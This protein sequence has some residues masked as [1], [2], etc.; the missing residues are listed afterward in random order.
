M[1]VIPEGGGRVLEAPGWLQ[2]DGKD[3]PV[4]SLFF[5]VPQTTLMSSSSP[6]VT[7]LG[8]SLISRADGSQREEMA[9]YVRREFNEKGLDADPGVS[10]C[11]YL[12][13]KISGLRF[14]NQ[15]HTFACLV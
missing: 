9:S 14:P 11:S 15:P 13:G 2:Q 7:C 5:L 4:I 6:R 1:T 12:Q 8:I 10:T 3:A